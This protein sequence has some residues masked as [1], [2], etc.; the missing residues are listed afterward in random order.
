MAKRIRRK[1]KGGRVLDFA[2]GH[3]L[4][5]HI[6]LI[7]DDTSKTAL[8][9]DKNITVNS[10]KLS[11]ALITGRMEGWMKKTLAVDVMR[12]MR[13]KTN[14]YKIVTQKIPSDIT[15]KNRLL[16]GGIL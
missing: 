8:A 15:P 9:V 4:L 14:G 3:G 10:K 12:A 1:Y 2:C 7:L 11:N 6:M 13:L 5:A 16:M